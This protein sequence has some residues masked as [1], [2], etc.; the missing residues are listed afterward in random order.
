MSNASPQPES[1]PETPGNN[2]Q[3]LRRRALLSG[4][5]VYGPAELTVN[6]TIADISSAG[7][8]L[9][10]STPEPLVEPLYLI[11]LSHGL[12]FKA[13][14]AWRKDNVVGLAFSEYLD[15]SKPNQDAPRVLRRLWV[16]HLR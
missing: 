3:E 8:R 12:A 14:V 10:F 13:R 1:P 7:A 6:C 16:E 2:R 11:D 4:C 5:V 9:R 15:L